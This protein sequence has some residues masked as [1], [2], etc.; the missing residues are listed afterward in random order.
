M[1]VKII[2][3]G[4]LKTY[5]VKCFYCGSILEFTDLDEF[6]TYTPDIPFEGQCTDWSIKCPKCNHNVPTR[7][8]TDMGY[9]DW[10]IKE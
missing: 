7:A 9:Y 10:R 3:E 1:A 4:K 5:K 6:S 2:S 8:M